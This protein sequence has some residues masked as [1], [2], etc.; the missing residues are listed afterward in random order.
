MPDSARSGRVRGHRVRDWLNDDP[1]PAPTV[2]AAPKG[3]LPSGRPN[4]S[5]AHLLQPL[6]PTAPRA[7]ELPVRRPLHQAVTP[8]RCSL[9][10][11]RVCRGRRISTGCAVQ[12][13]PTGF[14]PRIGGRG[15]NLGPQRPPGKRSPGASKPSLTPYSAAAHI[16]R[17][18]SIPWL[19]TSASDWKRSRQMQVAA[20]SSGRARPNASMVSHPS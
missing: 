7:A 17:M 11:Q 14:S 12:L 3:P 19:A 18:N 1:A 10:V 6:G 2:G 8:V 15:A 13:G 20:A 5:T 9:P 4:A 16:D